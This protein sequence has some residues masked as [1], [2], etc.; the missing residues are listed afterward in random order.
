MAINQVLTYLS[1]LFTC[2]CHHDKTDAAGA[3]SSSE[4]PSAEQTGAEPDTEDG[5]ATEDRNDDE[6]SENDTGGHE[7]SETDDSAEEDGDTGASS[8]TGADNHSSDETGS[9]PSDDGTIS[10]RE[11]TG[12][13]RLFGVATVCEG[14]ITLVIY[15]AGHFDGVGPCIA[16]GLAEFGVYNTDFTGSVADDG[17]VDGY[18]NIDSY[19]V[20]GRYPVTG[21]VTDSGMTLTWF[22]DD[23]SIDGSFESI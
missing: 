8:A 22:V 17:R 13:V 6:Q 4:T 12:T 16:E 5:D 3:R 1:V 19:T 11:Y 9:V 7:V 23:I 21:S 18:V 14:E 15:E 2:G 20:T 10:V